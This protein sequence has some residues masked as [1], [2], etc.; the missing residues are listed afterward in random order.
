[1]V[2]V[3][4][5]VYNLSSE[6]F[7]LQMVALKKYLKDEFSVEII[8]NSSNL[9]MAE[10]IRYHSEQ[11]GINYIKT[12]SSSTNSSDSHSF[13]ANF[14][15]QKFK[16]DYDYVLFLDHDCI[17]IK[18]FSV[19]EILDGGHVIAGIGQGAKKK[20]FWPGVVMMNL[21]A[22]DKEIVDFNPNGEFGLDT[23][24]NLYKVVEKYGME[25]CVFFNE[26]YHQNPY[27]NSNNYAHYALIN[28]GMFLHAINGSNWN[29]AERHEERINALINVIKEKMA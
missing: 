19:I 14:A 24:G 5:V 2:G 7:V 6:I 9:E 27:F 26:S 3:I 1:M 22:I 17:P 8:D 23:G 15:Y 12:F 4:I 18:H 10:N 29:G 20:Y 28:D 16:N 21:G 13:A 25:S 11:L